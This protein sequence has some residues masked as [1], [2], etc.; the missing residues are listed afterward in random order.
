MNGDQFLNLATTCAFDSS[1]SFAPDSI[2]RQAAFRQWCREQ[3]ITS[4]VCDILIKEGFSSKK[5]LAMAQD[6]DVVAMRITPKA[7]LRAVQCALQELKQPTT[8]TPPPVCVTPL[9]PPPGLP[10]PPTESRK[11]DTVQGSVLD[12]LLRDIAN[13]PTNPTQALA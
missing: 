8:A 9:R 2:D 12:S 13:N 7:Q 4:D 1:I 10:H 6:E 5:L 3:E 11:Q